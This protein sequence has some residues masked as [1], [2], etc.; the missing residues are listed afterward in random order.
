MSDSGHT[1][2]FRGEGT[3]LIDGS[4]VVRKS[5]SGRI[6]IEAGPGGVGTPQWRT[7][8]QAGSFYAVRKAV[9]SGLA[10]V[11]GV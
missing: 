8:D 6:E 1:A 5:A 10:V 3:L 4:V 9:Y 2:E 11:A 7:R